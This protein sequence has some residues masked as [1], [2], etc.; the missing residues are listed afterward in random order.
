MVELDH[1]A[2][3]D[4]EIALFG[5][6]PPE[7][8]RGQGR[9][10]MAHALR[11]AWS[12]KINRVWLHTCTLDDPKAMGFYQ[13]LGFRPYARGIEIAGDPRLDGYL[14]ESAAPQ[15]PVIKR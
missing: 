8:G 1:A 3:G 6:T 5:L 15:V 2:S 11:L 10:M 14:P 4:V 7:T 12:K 9:A 13:K